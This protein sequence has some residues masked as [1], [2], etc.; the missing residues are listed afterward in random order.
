M[1]EYLLW[2]AKL[3]TMLVLVV[4]VVPLLFGAA[5][6]T[7]QGL[8]SRGVAPQGVVAVVELTG[9]IEGSRKVIEE[10]HKQVKDDR[11]KGI[12]LRID[13]PGGAVGPSQAIFETVRALKG[14]KPIVASMGSVA[15]SGGL[16]AALGASKVYAHPGTLTG[17]IGVVM[18]FPNLQQV[19]DKLGVDVIT[20]TSGRLKDVGNMFRPMSESER[21]FLEQILN[22]VHEQFIAAVVEGR[23]LD[24]E[25]VREFSDGRVI[26]GAQ[27]ME[28]GLVDA[29]GGVP[30]AA[31]EVFALLGEPLPEG[32]Y[33]SLVYP[34][35]P[36]GELSKLLASSRS[37]FGRLQSAVERPAMELRFVMQ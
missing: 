33:P 6:G 37:L 24:P 12:V 36:F 15:A 2:L 23:N 3:I 7:M 9:M 13:S 28:Y 1:K 16:Y 20:L 27:A 35:E 18:Q 29:M 25:R 11:V 31:R 34:A 19:S 4:L 21:E 8:Q 30:E 5:I 10:L 22:R 17:S 14:T 26:L 32:E